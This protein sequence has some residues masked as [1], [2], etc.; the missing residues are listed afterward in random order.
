MSAA[1]RERVARRLVLAASLAVGLMLGGGIAWAYWTATATARGPGPLRS[2]TLTLTVE[3]D[4]ADLAISPAWPG[5]SDS[6]DALVRNTGDVTVTV[7][8]TQSL[9]AGAAINSALDVPTVRLLKDD[10]GV[11]CA[12]SGGGTTVTLAPGEATLV[13]ATAALQPTAP[14][15]VQGS[16]TNLTVL[17]EAVQL[18][19][20]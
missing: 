15:E 14:T 16:T 2:G 12:T 17:L 20:P 4:L 11:T 1:R 6:D 19:T 13:C 10:A 8:A 7:T 3:N 5:S 18:E 9:S